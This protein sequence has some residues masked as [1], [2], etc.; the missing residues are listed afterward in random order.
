M[1]WLTQ[2]DIEAKIGAR[3][4]I[5]LADDDKDGTADPAVLA[6]LMATAEKEAESA[7]AG[8]TIPTEAPWPPML[9]D[10]GADCAIRRLY[11]RRGL[12]QITAYNDAYGETMLDDLLT[13]IREGKRA[14]AGL[15]MSAS[16]ATAQADRG[17]E[18]EPVYTRQ[19]DGTLGISGY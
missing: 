9:V 19:S 10:L 3:K 8:Y 1:V 12:E 18:D 16:V 14:L 17:D 11:Q 7:L 2:T 6:A 4:V 15:T 5:E 13:E